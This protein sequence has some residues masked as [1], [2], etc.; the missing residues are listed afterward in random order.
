M[1]INNNLRLNIVDLSDQFLCEHFTWS[2]IC[3]N[4]TIL[5]HVNRITIQ[6][7]NIEVMKRSKHRLTY[8]L[9]RI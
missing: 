9:Y 6:G 4:T 2:P 3:I 8:L 5:H 7:C 1:I